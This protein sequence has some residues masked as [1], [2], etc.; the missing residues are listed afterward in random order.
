MNQ[1]TTS[2]VIYNVSTF[3]MFQH[4][5]RIYTW[6]LTFSKSYKIQA[7]DYLLTGMWGPSQL[8]YMCFFVCISATKIC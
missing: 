5:S 4:S 2:N 8:F 7:K 6:G 1:S 3:E